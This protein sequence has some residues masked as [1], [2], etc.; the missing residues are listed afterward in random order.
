M[1]ILGFLEVAIRKRKLFKWH[2]L[3]YVPCMFMALVVA[4]LLI[5]AAFGGEGALFF[6][7]MAWGALSTAYFIHFYFYVKKYPLRGSSEKKAR[8]ER[9]LAAEIAAIKSELSV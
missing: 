7:G 4:S 2:S 3:A 6:L 8:R 5:D 9:E 1:Q